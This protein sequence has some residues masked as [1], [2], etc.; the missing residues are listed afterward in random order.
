VENLVEHLVEK[1]PSR[2]G[3]TRLACTQPAAG[4]ETRGDRIGSWTEPA[5]R[6][7]D[8]RHGFGHG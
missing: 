7:Q 4:G 3:G 2:G 1:P 8:P 5:V 6:H